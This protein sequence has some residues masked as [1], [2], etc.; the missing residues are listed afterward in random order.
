LAAG[1]FLLLTKTADLEEACSALAVL[2]KTGASRVG[3]IFADRK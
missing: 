1:C 3:N 2:D